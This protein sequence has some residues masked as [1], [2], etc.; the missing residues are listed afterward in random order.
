MTWHSR[1]ENQLAIAWDQWR[2]S[3]ETS[4]HVWYIPHGGIRSL[5]VSERN[6]SDNGTGGDHALVSPQDVGWFSR[7]QFMARMTPI[8]Q[9]IPLLDADGN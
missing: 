5:A 7:E 4:G 2:R 8:A 3:R 9:K 1:I 6:P